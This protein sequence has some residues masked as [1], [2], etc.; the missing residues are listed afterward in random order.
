MS[1]GGSL[2]PVDLG[3]VRRVMPDAIMLALRYN[4]ARKAFIRARGRD[5][6]STE[7][8]HKAERLRDELAGKDPARR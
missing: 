8:R 6:P 2:P 5:K 4:D 7:L 3:Y 1:A